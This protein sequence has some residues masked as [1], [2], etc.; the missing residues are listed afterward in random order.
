MV[1]AASQ[2]LGYGAAEMGRSGVKSSENASL[3]TAFVGLLGL[4]VCTALIVV[5][6]QVNSQQTAELQS[7]NTIEFR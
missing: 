6:L 3:K 2:G 4:A 7:S 5:A 1:Q